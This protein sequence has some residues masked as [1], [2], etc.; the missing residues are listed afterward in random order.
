MATQRIV[1]E[2]GA[3]PVPRVAILVPTDLNEGGATTPI[4][5]AFA[6]LNTRLGLEDYFDL[7]LICEG[8]EFHPGISCTKRRAVRISLPGDV[9]RKIAPVL[10][11]GSMLYKVNRTVLFISEIHMSCMREERK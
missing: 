6:R 11:L 9:L 4:A 2:S 3:T 8:C 1:V 5:D 10:K 7:H